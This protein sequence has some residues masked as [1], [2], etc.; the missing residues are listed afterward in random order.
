LAISADYINSQHLAI[1]ADYINSQ[2]FLVNQELS[3]RV[4]AFGRTIA[5]LNLA[6]KP[7]WP[8]NICGYKSVR[9]FFTCDNTFKIKLII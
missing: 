8:A 2:H 7:S 1:S 4:K 6:S 3:L 9:K 5:M